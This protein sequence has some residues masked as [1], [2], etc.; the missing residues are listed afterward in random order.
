M[1]FHAEQTFTVPTDRLLA[2][3]TDAA[4]YPTLT[5]LP[6]ISAPE[7]VDHSAS[8]DTVR[9]SLRQRY[10]GDIPS[11]ALTF[12]DP[13][14]LS[15]VEE[16]VFDLDRRRA[17]SRLLPDHYP[18]RL[19]C[20]GVYVFTDTARGSTRRLEGDLRVRAPLVGGRVEKALVSGLQEHAVAE[21]DLIERRLS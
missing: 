20:S 13:A 16:L 17:T 14:R 1:R 15:W 4:F 9:I 11:A 18:D 3:F 19:T 2:L 8:G 5:G 21:Q 10:T 12:I 7:V 6:S